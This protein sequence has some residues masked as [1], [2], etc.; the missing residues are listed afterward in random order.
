M[1]VR[2]SDSAS[3]IE[4]NAY[5]AQVCLIFKKKKITTYYLTITTCLVTVS[6]RHSSVGGAADL[7]ARGPGFNTC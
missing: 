5:R 1:H 4:L 6:G 7:R 2:D 3:F